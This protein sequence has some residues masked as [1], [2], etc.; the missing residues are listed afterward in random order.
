[1]A[2]KIVKE[3]VTWDEVVARKERWQVRHHQALIF[4]LRYLELLERW[5]EQE[6]IWKPEPA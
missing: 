1:M 2:K 5:R 6:G 3:K 4:E